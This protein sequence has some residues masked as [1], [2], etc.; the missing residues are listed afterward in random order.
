MAKLTGFGDRLGAG[1]GAKVMST[2]PVCSNGS[3][4]SEERAHSGGN[5]KRGK[6]NCELY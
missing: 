4:E 1:V 3:W 5:R 2:F 6:F